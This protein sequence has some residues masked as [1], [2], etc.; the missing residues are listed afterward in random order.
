MRMRTAFGAL[1]LLLVVFTSSA[2]TA[3]AQE[4][5][6]HTQDG[7][8][9]ELDGEGDAFVLAT[10]TFEG[11]Q[12]ATNL[13]EIS[14]EIP[15]RNI[16]VYKV[17][18]VPYFGYGAYP[19]EQFTSGSQF[20]EYDL[21]PMSASTQ[22]VVYLKTP[23]TSKDKTTITLIYQTRDIANPTFQGLDFRFE[24]IKDSASTIRNSGAN[25][26]VP[27]DMTLKGKPQMTTTYLPSTFAGAAQTL[28]A[29]ELSKRMYDY[30][31][32]RSFQYNSKNLDP[33][34][35]FTVTGLYG[36]SLFML[37]FWEI[38]LAVILIIAV[39][40]AAKYFGLVVRVRDLFAAKPAKA[41]PK[42]PQAEKPQPAKPAPAHR[43]EYP[44]SFE[45]PLIMGMVTAF[46]Y[47]V[48]SFMINF[49]FTWTSG[50]YPSSA[51]MIPFMILAFI[52][53]F[54]MPVAALFGPALYVNRKY[55][56]KEGVL[57]FVFGLAFTVVLFFGIIIA[58]A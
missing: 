17:L 43:P 54:A 38:A 10:M 45:R 35:S 52:L 32:P 6:W 26:Y 19:Q 18:Q 29:P 8:N 9:V 46:L 7:Y 15:G 57:T 34:E 20:L 42:A 39:I 2:S 5:Y 47:L 13:Y 56:W 49:V 41:A 21:T 24:T 22:L 28:A 27:Q 53:V 51:F 50:F 44:F 48:V 33:G 55:G 30:Y 36:K 37:H 14:L 16:R 40:M 12:E 4:L 1:L 25:V 58:T 23:I 31:Y 11:I 3:S